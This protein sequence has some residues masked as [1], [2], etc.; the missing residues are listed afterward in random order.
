[1]RVIKCFSDSGDNGEHL[2]GRHTDGIPVSHELCGVCAFDVV[3]RDPQLA[4]EFATIMHP[5][6]MRVPKRGSKLGFAVEAFPELMV[7][8]HFGQQDLQRVAARQPGMLG[9]VDLAHPAGTQQPQDGVASEGRA[10]Q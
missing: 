9:Q 4:I 1:M 2:I 8:G 6:D 5:D 7:G 10:A 3:H